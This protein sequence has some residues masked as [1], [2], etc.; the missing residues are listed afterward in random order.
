M[1]LWML[2][3]IQTFLWI[4][5]IAVG[6]ASLYLIYWKRRIMILIMI[7]LITAFHH[8][9]LQRIF[10]TVNWSFNWII[11]TF[12][13]KRD[14]ARYYS[15]LSSYGFLCEISSFPNASEVTRT[16]LE[17]DTCWN[18]VLAWLT[19]CKRWW[20]LWLVVSTM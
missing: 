17:K 12:I 2:K 7:V 5:R 3:Y 16:D 15:L 4:L 13:Y 20:D 1:F 19:K 18:I 11:W 9:N 10:L 14:I 8:Y 6:L